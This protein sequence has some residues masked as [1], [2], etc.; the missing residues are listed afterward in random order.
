[1]ACNCAACGGGRLRPHLRVAG[2][3]GPEGLIPTTDR[4]G[5]ALSDIVRC[6]DC[7]HMQLARFPS[8]AELAAAYAG[9]ESTDY[10][11]EESGQRATARVMLTRIERHAKR[12]RLLDLGCWTGFLLDEAR[13]RGW[14]TTGVEPSAFA[15]S[16]AR[17]RLGLDVRTDDLFA[18]QLDPGAFD[19]IVLGD[20]IEHLP[21][22]GHALDRIGSL[23]A[24]GGVVLLL[25]PDAGSLV[26]RALGR[27]WWSVIP[28]HVQY[29]TR[30]SLVT[31]LERHG[32]RP[33]E[34]GTAPKA[35]TV[36]YYL[37]RIGG[38]SRRGSRALVALAERASVADRLWSADFHDRLAVVART[39]VVR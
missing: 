9:A 19:A 17:E 5:T 38:Y 21:D 27:R 23:S 18:A 28:T 39:P 34:L 4:F 35:F 31:L 30:R 11:D 24:P 25:L 33:L 12:G 13:R 3:A 7:G 37:D 2:A 10:I 15:S 36:R 32:F 8:R 6:R 14:Q 22:P 26:A 16:F 20:V 29:F 1:M